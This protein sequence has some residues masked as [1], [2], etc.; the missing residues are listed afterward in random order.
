M[1]GLAEAA[2]AAQIAITWI[3]L[4]LVGGLSIFAF[5]SG[6]KGLHILALILGIVFGIILV[7][8]EIRFA[9]LSTEDREDP[10]VVMWFGR[11]QILA[12]ACY[13]V[14]GAVAANFVQFIVRNSAS[15]PQTTGESSPIDA[16]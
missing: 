6:R 4:F 7:P 9:S 5:S 14:M 2:I 1:A 13:A 11:F 10:D 3:G 12:Y 15:E 16:R 8:W